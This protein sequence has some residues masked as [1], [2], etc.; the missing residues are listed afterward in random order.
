MLLKLVDGYNLT[1]G[2]HCFGCFWLGNRFIKF[3][4][5][6][7]FCVHS[8]MCGFGTKIKRAALR[9]IAYTIV[10]PHSSQPGDLFAAAA[11]LVVGTGAG[12][13]GVWFNSMV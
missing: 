5:S 3:D 9:S 7:N 10:A 4:N 1:S 11:S 13:D 2:G 12:I 6:K 8:T